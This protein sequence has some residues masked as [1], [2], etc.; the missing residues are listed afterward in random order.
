[1][2]K[3]LL[4]QRYLDLPLAPAFLKRMIGQDLCFQD[5]ATVDPQLYRTLCKLKAACAEGGTGMLDGC[6]IEDL[7]LDMTLP[8]QTQDPELPLRVRSVLGADM[9]RARLTPRLP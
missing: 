7:G 1:M 2:G 4:D 9:W 6:P 8:G 3:A 5:L